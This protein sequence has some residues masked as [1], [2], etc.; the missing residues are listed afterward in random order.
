MVSVLRFVIGAINRKLV[1]RGRHGVA[2]ALP[3]AVLTM[4]VLANLL[5][6]LVVPYFTIAQ[7]HFIATALLFA[8]AVAI[9]TVSFYKLQQRHELHMHRMLTAMTAAEQARAQAEAA[10][11]EKSRML[12]TMSHE[13]R[14]PLNGVIG[15]LGLLLETDLSPEQRNYSHTADASGRTLLSIIDEILD[16]A[17]AEAGAGGAAKQ[18]DVLGLIEGVTELLAP[19]AHA[20]V[21]ICA[22]GK[23][24]SI[25]RAMPSSLRKRV[26]WRLMWPSMPSRI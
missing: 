15:M 22:C 1:W 16:T 10:S 7:N 24:C 13:I 20:K 17:K 3:I 5:L 18:V 2:R 25:W 21:M 11:R 6:T 8:G 9:L 4:A 19:R 14:T 12:A 23:F 26:A